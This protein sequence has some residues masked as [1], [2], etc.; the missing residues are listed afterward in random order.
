MKIEPLGDSAFILRDLTQPAFVLAA[1]L[2]STRPPGLVEAVAGYDTVG[3]FIDPDLFDPATISDNGAET[4]P[5]G[6]LHSVPVCYEM[7]ADL[8]EAAELLGLSAKT[9]IEA[10]SGQTYRCFAV[11]FCPG[12]PYLG[13][14]DERVAGLRRRPTPRVRV[15]P[16][17]VAITGHQ[18][19]IYPLPR[20][21][22]WWLIGRTP[23]CLVDVDDDYFPIQAGD[24]VRFTRISREEFVAREGERL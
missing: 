15:E 23:L 19:G 24:E 11:G 22:G 13:Y 6:R 10:H 17:S 8:R 3:L 14:L 20:P 21:G 1:T 2:N 9:L 5:P 16:G 18:T 4:P 12:F 7:G